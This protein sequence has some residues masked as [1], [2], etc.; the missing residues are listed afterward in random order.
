MNAHGT[1]RMKIHHGAGSLCIG[2]LG[3]ASMIL[4]GCAD[5]GD[6]N[7]DP[8]VEDQPVKRVQSAVTVDCSIIQLNESPVDVKKLVGGWSRIASSS[9]SRTVSCPRIPT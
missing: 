2:G 6:T 1:N 9:T 7:A 5:V 8:I 4:A 3:P